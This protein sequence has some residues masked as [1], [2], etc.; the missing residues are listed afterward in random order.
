MTFHHTKDSY[1]FVDSKGYINRKGLLPF[2]FFHHQAYYFVLLTSH[3][4]L[5]TI[6]SVVTGRMYMDCFADG[7]KNAVMGLYEAE[8]ETY[9][10]N[11]RI[12]LLRS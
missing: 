1:R 3:A 10:K 2:I 6:D 8:A 7:L 12:T 4:G 9:C 5:E 11:H